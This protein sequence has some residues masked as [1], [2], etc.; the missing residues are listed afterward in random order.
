MKFS[1]ID[2]NHSGY[3]LIFF[4]VLFVVFN[5]F[6]PA[7]TSGLQ[8]AS[9]PLLRRGSEGPQVEKL[10]NELR[11]AGFKISGEDGYYGLQTEIAVKQFQKHMDLMEDGLAGEET[12][13]TLKSVQEDKIVPLQQVEA[14]AWSE[15]NEIFD[16]TDVVLVT[17][18]ESGLSLRVSRIYGTNHADV[19]PINPEDAEVLK[20]IFGGEW[21]WERRPVVVQIQDR[22]LAG[23]ITGMPH[24]ENVNGH[25]SDNNFAGHFDIHFRGS[26]RHKDN[27]EDEQHQNKIEKAAENK[28]PLFRQK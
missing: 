16:T 8:S 6:T 21:S 18:I 15:V 14:A 22:L 19:E 27:A 20:K 10:Q 9:F 2:K 12:R 28:W 13:S 4:L 25:I 26:R 7:V 1:S 23:S 11:G 5:V 3:I 24:G 17:D